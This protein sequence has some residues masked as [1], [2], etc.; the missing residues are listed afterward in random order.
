MTSPF[1]WMHAGSRKTHT[2]SRN[3]R[4]GM[5]RGRRRRSHKKWFPTRTHARR[6]LPEIPAEKFPGQSIVCELY[7]MAGI[8]SVEIGSVM[9]GRADPSSGRFVPPPMELVRLAIPRRVYT[10]SHIDYVIESVIEVF[11]N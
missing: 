10:Q 4:R 9:F 5:A 3:G 6:L 8:R 2:S 1:S 7:R 11:Q